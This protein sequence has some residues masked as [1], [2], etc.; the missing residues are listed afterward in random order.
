MKN[1]EY[2]L[3]FCVAKAESAHRVSICKKW[4]LPPPHT[5][6]QRLEISKSDYVQVQLTGEAMPTQEV[7][8]CSWIGRISFV[9]PAVLRK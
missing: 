9:K 4:E 8:P 5:Q 6:F 2:F 1:E 7:P 3:L